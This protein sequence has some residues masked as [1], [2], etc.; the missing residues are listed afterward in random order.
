MTTLAHEGMSRD[1]VLAALRGFL[2]DFSL[3]RTEDDPEFLKTVM[4]VETNYG[5]DELEEL[6][7]QAHALFSHENPI[8]GRARHRELE[9]E[10]LGICAGLLSGGRPG[11]VATIT[12]GGTESIFNGVHCARERARRQRPDVTRPKWVASHCAHPGITKACHFL[13][14]E[15]VRVPDRGF[16]ADPEAMAAA[17]DERTIGIYASAPSF[18]F[19]LYDDVPALGRLAL[20]HDLWLHVDACVGGFIAPWVARLG[21]AL[22]AWDLSVPGVSSLSADVHKFGYGMKPCSVVA[23][24][25][26][27]LLQDHYVEVA[28]WPAE[29]YVT[30]GFGGSRSMGPV[31]AAWAVMHLLGER[32]YLELT[33]RILANRDR[34]VAGLSAI[35]GIRLPIGEP[36]LNIVTYQGVDVTVGQLLN[37][38]GERG[39]PHFDVADPPLVL[40]VVDPCASGIIER[41]LADVAEV[42]AL[43]RE[44][45]IE[46]AGPGSGYGILGH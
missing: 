31:A 15:L 12:S 22:P 7:N 17:V 9:E 39:Y 34:L 11:V 43:A 4:S 18:P 10:L 13:G 5:G 24:R 20:A 27:S 1:D 3:H 35:D 40:L 21:R 42:V 41:Y 28:D 6:R 45:R 37:G 30:A 44:G 32:G 23:W 8:M 25:D 26:S 46:D 2:D 29:T 36:E 16:R 19:G 38:L 33:A 14:I